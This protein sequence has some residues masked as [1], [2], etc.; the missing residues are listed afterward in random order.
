MNSTST[1][2]AM[3]DSC[4]LA[5]PVPATKHLTI[6]REHLVPQ[7]SGSSAP[8]DAFGVPAMPQL[9][10][11]RTAKATFPARCCHSPQMIMIADSFILES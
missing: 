10:W 9:L 6:D 2:A 11:Q 5:E 8:P 3:P 1:S 4:P 7:L